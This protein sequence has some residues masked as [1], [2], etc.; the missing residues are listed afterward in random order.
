MH[1][2]AAVF[3]DGPTLKNA[4]KLVKEIYPEIMNGIKVYMCI[5]Y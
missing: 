1:N 3:R 5:L 2:N 4:V